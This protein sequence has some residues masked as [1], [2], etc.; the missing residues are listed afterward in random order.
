[1]KKKKCLI[2]LLMLLAFGTQ[3]QIHLVGVRGNQSTDYMDIVKWQALDPASVTAYPSLLHA[4]YMAS[5]VFDAYNSKYYI[6]G[7][8]AS[9]SGLLEFNTV[10]N[11]QSLL[12][13]SSFSNTSEIDMSTGKIYSLSIDQPG[14]IKVNEYDIN[15]GTDTLIGEVY[16]PGITGIAMDAIGFDSNNG[17][18]YYVGDDG[19]S[20]LSLFGIQVRNPVFT[21]TKTALT[22]PSVGTNMMSINYDNANNTIY[23]LNFESNSSGSS[24]GTYV[25]EIN[26]TTGEVINRGQLQG[27][28]GF[29]VGSSSFDQNSGSFLLVGYNGNPDVQMIVFDTYNNTYQ[30]GFMPDNVSEIV[31]DNYDFAKNTYVTTSVDEPVDAAITLSPNP[32][33][34]K[35]TIKTSNAILGQMKASI[36]DINGKMKWK[37]TFQAGNNTSVDIS[38]LLPGVYMLKTESA[39]RVENHKFVVR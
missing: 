11:E 27:F 23:A 39:N 17:I 28:Q 10:T 19:Q 34:S 18:I 36:F 14:Y 25:V 13:Y 32:A 31:C 22:T 26:K 29:L 24:T 6:T 37:D 15:T 2:S 33:N 38:N 5:S 16:D 4:Y 30:T 3:A 8:G 9:A 20:I 21:F 12:N 1:M 35:I 7:I